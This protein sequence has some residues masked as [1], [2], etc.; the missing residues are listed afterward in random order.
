MQFMN[1]RLKQT[2]DSSTISTASTTTITTN[3]TTTSTI[4]AAGRSMILILKLII[5]I[6]LS[7][8]V[9]EQEADQHNPVLPSP[10]LSASGCSA[11]Y[12]QSHEPS[13]L[14]DF[15]LSE[16]QVSQVTN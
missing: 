4:T 7:D 12:S 16:S 5:I 14:S 8:F 9:F 3:S 6:F 11:S 13:D 10:S 1:K 2:S 15:S